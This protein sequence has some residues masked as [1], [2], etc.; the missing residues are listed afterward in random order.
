MSCDAW[1]V[2]QRDPVH[3]RTAYVMRIVCKDP[4]GREARF[5]QV[6]T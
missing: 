2:I 3:L 4:R 6:V 5:M 1:D